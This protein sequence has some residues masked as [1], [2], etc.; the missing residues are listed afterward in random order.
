[1]ATTG[2]SRVPFI[3]PGL[4]TRLGEALRGTAGQDTSWAL[5]SPSKA[6]VHH[7]TKAAESRRKGRLCWLWV[8]ICFARNWSHLLQHRRSHSFVRYVFEH[9]GVEV[10]AASFLT[11]QEKAAGIHAG[12]W[13]KADCLQK[14]L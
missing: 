11:V 12:L 8:Q 7:L 6:G 5:K 3:K 1:M 2:P 4:G 10:T 13:I 14:C 9:H